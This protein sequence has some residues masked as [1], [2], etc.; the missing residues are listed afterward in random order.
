M[1]NKKIYC[2]YAATTFVSGEVMQEMMPC[3]N[4]VWG[5][6]SSLHSFGREAVALVDRA[7]DRVAKA[8]NAEKSSEVYFTSGGTEANN[9][10][11]KG[12]A[13]ANR[14]KGNHIITSA[15]EHESVLEAC[16]QLEAEGFVVTYLP[17]DEHGLVSITDLI[18]SI[19]EKTSL[20]SV[21]S[22]NNEVGT[23]QNIKTIAN[24]AHE[25]GAIFHTD[26]VQAIGALKMNVKD[27]D[28]DVM[29]ISGH[30]IYAP[31]GVG[32]LY[33]KNGVKIEPI[34]AGGNQERGLRA[35]T[36]NV[37]SIVGFGK[38][39][40][41]ATRDLVINQKKLKS[42]RT[43]FLSKVAENIS[44][45]QV[46]GHPYQKV[47]ATVN[48]SFKFVEA[49][50]LL[51]LLDMAGIAVSTGSAC[52]SGSTLPSHVLK[53]M[54]LST[55]LAKGTIRFSF[56]KSTTKEDVDYIVEKLTESVAKLR[57]LSPKSKR[58]RKRKEDK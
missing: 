49:E 44:D 25:Y 1:M 6:A 8:I 54:G 53:A 16:R 36:T 10:A 27:M 24:I 57:E 47:Q 13:R 23:V 45:V 38:A 11:I 22:V 33:V 3:F 50:A 46:N 18:H 29:S 4:T 41:I 40:E 20:V 48:I 30:K 52:T 9:W 37:P 58:G 12:I 28:V 19:N 34:L 42:I 43:Y 5:N 39:I 26:A 31:K 56:G 2:D 21:M 17:V 14:A 7:R 35:G 55:E 15:I 32:A 51:T